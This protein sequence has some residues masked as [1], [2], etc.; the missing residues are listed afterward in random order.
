MYISGLCSGFTVVY[1]S[2]LYNRGLTVVCISE[3]CNRGLTVVYISGLCSGGPTVVYISGLCNRGLTV[4]H[5]SGLCNRGLT[6]VYISGLM[7]PAR[8][9]LKYRMGKEPSESGTYASTF[10]GWETAKGMLLVT[11]WPVISYA[12]RQEVFVQSNVSPFENLV[13]LRTV[14]PLLV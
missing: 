5:T 7:E 11:A 8:P 12:L 6:V 1:I 9:P 13:Q 10:S 2:G 3:L 4:V 14:V